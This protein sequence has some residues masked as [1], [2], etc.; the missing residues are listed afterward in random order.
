MY[1]ENLKI[2]NFRKFGVKLNNDNSFSPAIDINFNKNLNLLVGENDS[3]KTAIIDAIK[4]VVGTQSNDW[5]KLYEEDFHINKTTGVRSDW[6]KIEC[7]F[8]GFETHEAAAFLEWVS[9]NEKEE[10]ILKLTMNARISQK[11][12]NSFNILYDIKAGIDDEGT[13]LS[14]EARERIRAT[15]LKPLRDAEAELAPKKGS[16]LSQILSAYKIFKVAGKHKLETIMDDA[17]TSIED[18]FTKEEGKEVLQTINDE[19]L[20]EFAIGDKDLISQFK[21][22]EAGLKRI[23]EKLELKIGNSDDANS[24]NLGLGSNNLLFI[25]TE[26]LLLKKEEYP[27]LKMALVEEIEAHL[28]PQSQLNL[29][30]F[31]DN[32]SAQLGFQ[33]ILTTHSPTLASKIDINNIILCKNGDAFSLQRGQTKLSNGDYLFLRRFLDDTKANLFF[34]NGIIIVEG[35]AENMIIPALAEYIER[36]LQKFGVSIV[37]VNSTALLRYSKIFQRVDGN[38]MGIPVACVTDR[39]IPPKI[40][41]DTELV[42]ATRKTENEYSDEALKTKVAEKKAKYEGGDVKTYLSPKWTLEYDIALSPLKEIMHRAIQM[43]IATD[44]LEKIITKKEIETVK[45][46]CKDEIDKWK[47][48]GKPDDEIAS[49]IYEPLINKQASKAV[50]AQL[51]SV[52][53]LNTKHKDPI[54]VSDLEADPNLKYLIDAINYTT[55]KK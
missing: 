32:N 15:Y 29:V 43:A 5:I 45:R 53:L 38:L 20:K 7:L 3:G 2:W 41:K 55:R 19:Y 18:Y 10:Y 47:Q 27:G 16:R 13:I 35:P 8:K 39:D 26:L 42:M 25:A 24:T 17:N 31:L 21:L 4:F 37:N 40:A 14:A 34:A 9:L 50:V 54:P 28:H 11:S 12:V 23:L 46:Q 22:S 52:M 6:L 36:P 33:L 51:F 44:D 48:D 30:E 49:L 1:L